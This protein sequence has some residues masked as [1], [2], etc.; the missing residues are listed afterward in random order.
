MIPLNSYQKKLWVGER[1][2][3]TLL[4]VQALTFTSARNCFADPDRHACWQRLS[5]RRFLTPS[6]SH[7]G[8]FTITSLLPLP[9]RL[10]DA[11]NI[12]LIWRYARI[13][14][15]RRARLSLAPLR[16]LNDLPDPA[17][18][19]VRSSRFDV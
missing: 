8:L 2:L 13:T 11:Y 12:F 15:K 7:A 5:S 3:A 4:L 10:M 18:A 17:E 19:E 1:P 16:D 9:W 6:P 14:Y